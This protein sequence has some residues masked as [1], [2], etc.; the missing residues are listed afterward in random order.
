MPDRPEIHGKTV[1]NL[2]FANDHTCC[3]C[4]TKGK[5]VQVHHID[6]NTSNNAPENLAVLCLD[7][8][9]RVTGTEGLGRAYTPGELGQYK[10]TWEYMTRVRLVGAEAPTSSSGGEISYF[11]RIVCEILS[12]DD[13]DP[14]IRERLQTLS[15]LN[16]VAGCTDDILGALF[17]FTVASTMSHG[18][19]AT[20]VANL[21][22]DL[23]LHLVG[24][25]HVTLNTDDE[26]RLEEGVNRLD[27]I[28][29][30]HGEFDKNLEVVQ[31]ACDNLY[32]MAGIASLYNLASVIELVV[33]ALQ[34]TAE[35]CLATFEEHKEP[36][37]E[38]A[39]YAEQTIQKVRALA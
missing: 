20:I 14:R 29:K 2:M 32:S 18:Q 35:G 17:Y 27:T 25:A 36:L 13:G 4:R 12:M 7:C 9:S 34:N 5:N 26:R 8:H 28:G 23:F 1:D 19:T 31:A 33:T 30:F 37:I 15:H 24:P 11:D 10:R 16:I 21:I 22:P 38:G 6:G 39:E 3:V